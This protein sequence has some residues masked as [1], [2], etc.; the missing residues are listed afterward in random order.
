[1]KV[2]RNREPRPQ[3]RSEFVRDAV[4]S[5]T[6][7]NEQ[8]SGRR[9]RSDRKHD[10]PKDFSGSVD[11]FGA[12]PMNIF[13]DPSKLQESPDIL[14]TW[15]HLYKREL[16]IQVTHP[17]ANYFQKMAL[18]TKQG[19]IWKFPIDN[20]Q[21]MEDE[22]ATDF[23]EHVFLEQYVEDWCPTK[24]PIRHFMELVCV[25]LSK[26]PYLTAKEKKEHIMWYRDYFESKKDILKDLM[27]QDK[28]DSATKSAQNKQISAN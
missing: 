13:T 6:R 5:Q 10:H 24:G 19:K 27:S 26:N 28:M 15:Q 2:E 4:Q 12:K 20:E 16:Q 8:T 21:G 17:P 1:M 14:K 22:A 3:S 23:T 18:W 9:Q 11:L 25:G 7:Y